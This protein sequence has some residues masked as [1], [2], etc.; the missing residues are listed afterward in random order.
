MDP[1]PGFTPKEHRVCKLKKGFVRIKA[2]A[3]GMFGRL[4][5]LMKEFSFKQVMCHTLLQMT[6]FELI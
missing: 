1:P 4:S 2:V 5:Y 6:S 3:K